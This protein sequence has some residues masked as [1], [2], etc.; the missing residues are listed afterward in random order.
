[1]EATFHRV[2][3]LA[4]E[5]PEL[6]NLIVLR[7][8]S[9]RIPEKPRWLGYLAEQLRK[10]MEAGKIRK[11]DPENVA[12]SVWSSFLGFNL[13]ISRLQT[14]PPEAVEQMF[15]VQFDVLTRGIAAREEKP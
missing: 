12:L 6:Y 11:M 15:R 2:T 13:M 9:H 8:Y 14:L 10:G 4:Y 7:K 1:M 5:E 3:R